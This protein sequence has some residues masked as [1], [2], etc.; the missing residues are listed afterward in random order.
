M[1]HVMLNGVLVV[2]S[3]KAINFIKRMKQ[4]MLTT[5]IDNN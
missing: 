3:V 1:Y 4:H 5:N 2:Y